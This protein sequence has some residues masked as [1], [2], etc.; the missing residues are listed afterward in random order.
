MATD[1]ERRK[2]LEMIESGKISAAEGLHLMNIL[3]DIDDEPQSEEANSPQQTSSD[4]A[5]YS[6]SQKWKWLWYILLWMGI[7]LVVLG[8]IAMFYA[9]TTTG[10]SVWFILAWLPFIAGALW[11]IFAWECRS[12][13]WLYLHIHQRAGEKHGNFS[14]GLPL[15]LRFFY[16]LLRIFGDKISQKQKAIID[17]LIQSLETQISSKNPIFIDINEYEDGKRVQLVIG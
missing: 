9:I 4:A 6:L 14:L 12:A 13:H 17:Q 2:V 15:P 16:W 5:N 7:L 11:I 1:A 3:M 8:G 10:F